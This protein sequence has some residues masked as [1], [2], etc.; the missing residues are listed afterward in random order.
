VH[1]NSLLA[2]QK[3]NNEMTLAAF[4]SEASAKEAH[5]KA[6]FQAAL[7]DAEHRAELAAAK[8]SSAL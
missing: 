3:T 6:E 7:K 5:V 1:L 8:A 2:E 4:K